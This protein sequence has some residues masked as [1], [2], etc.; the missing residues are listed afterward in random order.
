MRISTAIGFFGPA[1]VIAAVF[2]CTGLAQMANGPDRPATATHISPR[3]HGPMRFH[4]MHPDNSVDSENWSG[5]AVTGSSFTKVTGSW[6]VPAVNCSVTPGTRSTNAYAAFWVGIDGYSSST[7][8]QIGTDSDCAYTKDG[9]VASYYAWYEF[10]PAASRDIDLTISPGDQ[11]SAEVS[12]SGS[13]FTATINDVT[14]GK[15]YTRTAT[16]RGA[17]RSSAEWIAESPCCTRGQ[18]FLPLS[19]FGTV[20]FGEDHTGVGSTNYATDSSAS[21]AISVFGPT[22][23]TQ[24]LSSNCVAQINMVTSGGTVEDNNLG[25]SGDGTSF[26]VTWVSE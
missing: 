19:D 9:S 5:Y 14:T 21:G 2:A 17:A 3:R 23:C 24:S 8:E 4:G 20:S 25:L 10:Y 22:Q 12:Y 13:E 7:V 26:Q 11:M 1:V 18:Q 15:S 16:V 6:T